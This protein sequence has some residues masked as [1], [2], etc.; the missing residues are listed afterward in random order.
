MTNKNS[1]SSVLSLM[2][3]KIHVDRPSWKLAGW[4][5]ES[6]K[7]AKYFFQFAWY[8]IIVYAI[9]KLIF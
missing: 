3:S 7:C 9:Y 2:K 8:T 6:W 4:K 1:I 5:Y